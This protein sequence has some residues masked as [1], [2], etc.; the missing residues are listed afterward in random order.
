[1]T[2][3]IRIATLAMETQPHIANFFR[4]VLRQ[5]Y[6]VLNPQ[7]VNL[8]L[9]EYNAVYVEYEYDIAAHID[10]HSKED[11]ILFLLRWA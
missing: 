1:M 2:Y 4:H 3:R 8:A 5:P 11:Y 10:F 9:K 7:T 6:S